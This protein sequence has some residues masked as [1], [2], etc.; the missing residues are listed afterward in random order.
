MTAPA[1]ASIASVVGQARL[2]LRAP[3]RIRTFLKQQVEAWQERR[4]LE[5]SLAKARPLSM[6]PPYR[7]VHLARVVDEVLR[8]GVPG[9]F[10]E[11]G[12]WR[13]GASFLMADRLRR[14]GV[15][16]RRVWLCDSFEGHRPPQA[17]DGAAALSYADDTGSPYYH[18]NCRV[19]VDDV[20]D[21]AR[22]LGLEPWTRIVKGWFDATLPVVRADIGAIAILRIDCDWY[23]SVRCALD[24]L[25]DSV[26]AGG[27]I[28]FDDYYDYDGCAI[29]V[30]EFLAERRLADRLEQY[31][32]VA[33]M[34]KQA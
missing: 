18:D 22:R 29:A 2:L 12:T 23:A 34:R 30:H 33:F 8:K 26:S 28:I 1:T 3:R 4:D 14:A 24:C 11:C 5:P 31:G 7:L 25:Y 15:S 16:G 21:S 20:R 13:G 32:G 19:D 17:I 6:L 9:D 10:I 27:V